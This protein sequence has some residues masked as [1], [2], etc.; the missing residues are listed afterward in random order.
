VALV[1]QP[2]CARNWVS[3]GRAH[4]DGTAAPYPTSTQCRRGHSA[5]H[6]HA[7]AEFVLERVRSDVAAH[8]SSRR[9]EAL[10]D[11]AQR[12][13]SSRLG[14]DVKRTKPIQKDSYAIDV[15]RHWLMMV[16]NEV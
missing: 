11:D 13:R 14:D 15:L 4:R 12:Q 8:I 2:A 5:K 1:S 7:S 3:N 16:V 6:R 9:C 10:G